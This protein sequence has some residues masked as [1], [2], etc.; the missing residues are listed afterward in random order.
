MHLVSSRE[1]HIKWPAL[2]P[3][4]VRMSQTHDPILLTRR[5]LITSFLAAVALPVLFATT[6]WLLPVRE[7][8]LS[9]EE[10]HSIDVDAF[11]RRWD[12]DHDGAISP[13]ELK[14]A[15]GNR[16]DAIAGKLLQ[17]GDKN[18]DGKID[19]GELNSLAAE[20][21]SWFFGVRR[22]PML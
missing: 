4:G 12:V 6:T 20:N 22:K 13:D 3:T 9:A 8:T 14:H 16:L 7:P 15:I 10:I 1:R 11:I 18:Q 5:S 19:P 21:F 17:A 2:D